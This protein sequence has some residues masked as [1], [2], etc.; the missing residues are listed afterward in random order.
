M[1]LIVGLGAVLSSSS[2]VALRDQ[3]PQH[4]IFRKQLVFVVIGVF[5]LVITARIPYRWY[6]RWAPLI[7]AV[8]VAGLLATMAIGQARGG[9]QRWI[10]V[11]P[12]TVQASEYAKFAVIVF[13][14]A[15]LTRKEQYLERFPHVF[16]PVAG[17]LGIVSVL[18]MLQPDLGTTLLISG[19]AFAVLVASTAPAR[20]IVGLG[21]AG[22]GAAVALAVLEPYRLARLL[23]FFSSNP[24]PLNEGLQV[25]QSLVALGT[26]GL[27]GV[28]LGASRAR[29]S[30]LPNAHTDFIFAII[31]EETGLAGALAVLA[32]FIVFAIVGTVIAMRAAD[33]FGRLLAIGIVTWL[34]LQA[35]INIG[36]VV[37]ALPITGIPLPFVSA[38]GNAMMVNLAVVGVLVNIARS[39]RTTPTPPVRAGEPS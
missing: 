22:A 31:G 33:Q 38:G 19:A 9:S 24:D 13:L 23:S 6:A 2:V 17:S 11:G 12:L 26:G 20:H 3:L 4:V 25:T 8:T 28:G 1:L 5:L 39:G 30:F 37:D 7:L 27:F 29:W 14:A 32:L 36:G 21:I 16:W 34:S 18:V 15:A 10:V 35:I